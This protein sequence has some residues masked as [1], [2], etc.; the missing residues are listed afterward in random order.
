MFVKTVQLKHFKPFSL[1]AIQSFS[2]RAS[3]FTQILIGD[4]GSGKSSLLNEVHPFAAIKPMYGKKGIKVIEIEHD[5]HEFVLTSDFSSSGGHHSFKMDLTELN[6]SGTS[7]IQNEL[8][9]HYLG[10]TPMVHDIT[11][12]NCLM[13]SMTKAERK[14]LI[15][16]INPVDLS[17]ILDKHRVAC[18]RL[19]EYKNNLQ[20]LHN[21]KN[22]IVSLLISQDVMK[23][24]LSEKKRLTEI[25]TSTSNDIFYFQQI[26]KKTIADLQ[27]FNPS[28]ES[29]PLSK[30]KSMCNELNRFL[31][32][33]TDVTDRSEFGLRES[34]LQ[35]YSEVKEIDTKVSGIRDRMRNVS[36][37]IA[38]YNSHIQ[39]LGSEMDIAALVA[40][41]E[42]LQKQILEVPPDVRIIPEED[43]P[44]QREVL[45][46]VL[47]HIYQYMEIHR[48]AVPN[49]LF[50]EKVTK[51]QFI[52]D[53][54][55]NGILTKLQNAQ[56]VLDEV[57]AQLSKIP[58][59]PS[60]E[61]YA[62]MCNECEYFKFF[63]VR[64]LEAN[65]KF[66]I[67]TAEI[68]KLNQRL[69]KY[70]KIQNTYKELVENVRSQHD[71]FVRLVD[72]LSTTVWHTTYNGLRSTFM[73]D[74]NRYIMD[75]KL[76]MTFSP[77][78]YKNKELITE[79]DVLQTKIKHLAATGHQS[80]NLLTELLVQK[81]SSMDELYQ[82][83]Y[84]LEDDREVAASHRDK[85]A[86]FLDWKERFS[87]FQKNF[88]E[89]LE[90]SVIKGTRIFCTTMIDER[91]R[92]LAEVNANL[93]AIDNTLKEQ[94]ALNARLIDTD[95]T[96]RDITTKRD[97]LQQ[98]EYSLSPHTGF[99][100]QNLINF[101]NVLIHNVNCILSQVW[102]YP[103][104]LVPLTERHSTDSSG[105]A[106]AFDGIFPVLVD[107]L[108]VSD[109]S[110]LSK[111]QQSIVDL[112]WTFAF[113]FAKNLTD[114][115][116]YLDE[117]DRALDPYHKQKLLEWLQTARD[118]RYMRQMW[119]V[120]HDLILFNGF[121]DAEILALMDNNI[122]QCEKINTHV[123]FD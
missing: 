60:K 49:P 23:H 67:L 66:T 87:A 120:G 85:Y 55:V 33:C 4:N 79:I 62:D 10:Y 93:L 123:S 46:Y 39:E 1:S 63:N 76:S 58:A 109:I 11:H 68:A 105:E 8:A 101:T 74:T 90:Y 107:D 22:E 111:G 108:L 31:T 100:N 28:I 17:V 110:K 95:L 56:K 14:K 92:E 47:K 83:W 29:F 78:A 81:Q 72:L 80:V 112:A 18:S 35:Y 82:E 102:S 12:M 96:I 5:G 114:Y 118:K 98:V 64:Y 116:V 77:C 70:L 106:N 26:L 7:G 94:D 41:V 13:S 84:K 48:G 122:L 119:L 86:E 6:I 97:L 104:Q 15:L 42:D 40:R 121:Q 24:L 88:N 61:D 65:D 115:P 113:I 21:K 20:L 37:E 71:D 69:Q 53:T 73:R 50:K 99:M 44:R 91:Q 57:N 54:R 89:Y 9:A 51:K 45:D 3:S 30:V 2:M 25:F 27:R 38:V 103:L 43:F 59:G 75:I 16:E 36:Q 19:R 34:H 117:V 32:T 52:V